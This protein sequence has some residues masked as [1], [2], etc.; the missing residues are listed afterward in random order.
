MDREP[1]FKGTVTETSH[2]VM[3]RIKGKDTKIEIILRQ[4][5]WRSGIRFRKNYKE[6]PGRPDIA[7]TK[8]KI[9]IFC[10]SEFFHGKNWESSRARV[11]AGSNGKYWVSKIERNI[12]R[13][14]EKD[15]ALEHIGWQSV[16]FWGR[17]ILKNT[18]RCVSLIRD[19]INEMKNN[20]YKM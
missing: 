13:D 3:S 18:G 7:I 17:D 15:R 8:Y 5:L 11:L 6:L 20:S 2:K 12:E 9:A 1:R 4:A 16:H 14:M 19:I 10:D